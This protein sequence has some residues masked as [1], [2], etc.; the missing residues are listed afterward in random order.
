MHYPHLY[1]SRQILGCKV[2]E[3]VP[4]C[5]RRVSACPEQEVNPLAP[6][7]VSPCPQWTGTCDEAGAG[8]NR[9]WLGKVG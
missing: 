9:P 5:T 3:E 2:E 7:V 6:L 1:T 8:R 4:V